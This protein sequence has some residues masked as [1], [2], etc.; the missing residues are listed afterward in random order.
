[1]SGSPPPHQAPAQEDAVRGPVRVSAPI[2][3]SVRLPGG[4]HRLTLRAPQVAAIAQPGQF[5]HIWCHDPADLP[6]PP[7]S[8]V[9]RRPY[10]I[11]RVW[12]GAAVE[13]ILRLR[14]I[15]SRLLAS[16]H[17]GQALDLIGPLGR[18]FW[19]SGSTRLVILVAG[20]CG[21]AVA[22]FLVET[23]TTRGVRVTV[24]AGGRN[25][26]AMPFLVERQPNGRATLPFLVELGAE[27]WFVSETTDGMVVTEALARC[28]EDLPT[29]GTE[30][31]AVGPRPML[32]R[33]VELAGDRF[34][35]QVSL[36][37]RMA[38]GVGACRSCVVPVRGG[39]QVVYHTVCREGP[40]FDG[41]AVV[42]EA[43]S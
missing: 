28:L 15:G 4:H 10:T 23:L 35:V 39:G 14:G 36:E 32:R 33:V 16:R 13:I 40:V 9:L 8:A 30:V 21:I 11:A 12:S 20:G 29:D 27:V 19:W 38:C 6:A 17:A 3:E 1:M 24:L 25:D 22:P 31:M 42:W 37:E 34:P 18:G 2:L 7:A 41:R 26:E 43:L 5:L